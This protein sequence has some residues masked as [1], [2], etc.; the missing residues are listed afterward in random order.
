MQIQELVARLLETNKKVKHRLLLKKNSHLV[1]LKLAEDL[2][3]TYYESWTNEPEKTHNAATA[4]EVL[5]ELIPTDQVKALTLWVKA[6]AGL[7]EGQTEKAIIFLD[8]AAQIFNKINNPYQAAQ[9]QVSKLY[10]LALLGRYDEAVEVGKK[11]SKILEKYKD[12]LTA[13]KI[14]MNLGIIFFRRELHSKAEI[15]YLSARKRFVQLEES[16][17]LT[18]CENNLAMTYAALND[19]RKSEKFYAQAF[20]R[21]REAQMHVTQA[22]IEA[23]MGNLALFRGRFNE[24]LNFW[25]APGKNMKCSRCRTNKPLQNLRLPTFTL[26]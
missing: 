19:F 6:I 24:A 10:A 1:N 21:A 5:L 9:T 16:V 8:E 15:F 23:S 26:N 11:A 17:W 22:E 18:M 13:G 25:K 2:K 20:Q 3:N 4:L 12:E 14:E 7:T